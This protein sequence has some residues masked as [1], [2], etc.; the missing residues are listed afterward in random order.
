[1]AKNNWDPEELHRL[2][3]AMTIG[4]CIVDR[5]K[6]ERILFANRS[7]LELYDCA[8]MEE[9]LDLTGGKFSGMTM[10]EDLSL[11]SARG[12]RQDFFTLQVQYLTKTR[13]I[14]ELDCIVTPCRMYDTDVYLLQMTSSQMKLEEVTSDECTGFPGA[15]AF[16]QQ[17]LSAARERMNEGGFSRFC[18]VCF[19]IANFRGFNRENGMEEGNRC[20]A[21]TARVLREVFPEGLFGHTSADNFYAILP[22]ENLQEKIEEA[23][24]RVDQYMGGRSSSLKAGIVLFD[25]EVSPDVLRHAFD[26]ARIACNTVKNDAEHCCGVFRK[27]MQERIENR[28][29]ILD[30]FSEALQLGYLKVYY[31]PMVRALSGKVCGFE[32]LTRWED[33]VRG[34]I[35]PGI[36]VPILENAR[37][38]GRLDA[39]VIDRVAEFLHERQDAG[40][41]L[42]PVSVNFSRLD[43][44]LIHPLACLEDAVRTW[45]IP[46]EMIRAELTER[47]LEENQ[48]DMA[49]TLAQFHQA[50]YQLWLDDFGAEYSSLNALHRFDFDLIKLD[51]GFFRNFDEKSR[52]ILTSIVIM[53]KSLHIHTLAEGVETKEQLDF[54]RGIGCEIIQG[55][56]YGKPMPF[57]ELSEE[58]EKKGLLAETDAER[59]IYQAAGLVNLV[60]RT[61]QALLAC[62][63]ESARIITANPVF[64]QQ[65]ASTDT[66][67]PE[68]V[69]RYLEM[70]SFPLRFRLFGFLDKVF[71]GGTGVMGFS[72]HGQSFRLEGEKVAGTSAFWIA[73][74][75][76]FCIREETALRKEDQLQ[77]LAAQ[78]IAPLYDGI[79][80]INLPKDMITVLVSDR[81][82]TAPGLKRQGIRAAL[83]AFGTDLVYL[84]DRERFFAFLDPSG[85]FQ[86]ASAS[87]RGL[88][89]GLFRIRQKDGRYRWED[90]IAVPVFRDGEKSLLLY[91]RRSSWEE[92]P[93]KEREML[94]PVF[95]SS[96]GG[97][98]AGAVPKKQL[99]YPAKDL[100]RAACRFSGLAFYWLDQDLRVVGA[101]D[102]MLSLLGGRTISEIQ[103]RSFSELGWCLAPEECENV[104]KSILQ[105]GRPRTTRERLVLLHGVPKNLCVSEFPY[106][107][108]N[109]VA[110]IA[111]YIRLSIK[112]SDESR[113]DLD[114][115]TGFLNTYGILC[116]GASY[117]DAWRRG[118]SGYLGVCLTLTDYERLC[119]TL[120]KN[121]VDDA[122]RAIADAIRTEPLPQDAA[123]ARV[124]GCTFLILARQEN[125]ELAERIASSVQKSLHELREIGG[126]P[127]RLELA[128]S[129]AGA[130]EASDFLDLVSLL[131]RRCAKDPQQGDVSYARSL[132]RIGCEPE[133]FED[134]PERIV[135]LD[136]ETYEILYLNHAARKD[137]RL[138]DDFDYRG[139][140]C[141]EILENRSGICEKCVMPTFSGLPYLV[142]S[143]TWD[144]AS[145]QR[146]T[147][148]DMLVFWHG[149]RARLYISTPERVQ[150]E[151]V[152]A[153]ETW[154][155]E[156]IT[157]GLEDRDPSSGIGRSIACIGKNLQA[158]RLL[159][160]EKREGGTVQ[161]TYEWDRKGVLP[162]KPDLQSILM[163]RLA[164]L[165]R[166]FAARKVV[167]VEDYDA[168]LK[169]HPDFSLPIPQVRSFIAGHLFISGESLGF[170]LVLNAPRESF[171]PGG[172]MLSTLVDF[173]AVMLRTRNN[174]QK[175]T[176]QSLRD[177]MTG[178]LNRRGLARYL[179]KRTTTGTCTLL[180]GDINGLKR[181]NDTRG[182]EAGD[183]LIC[184]IADILL[185]FSDKEHVFRM[186]GDEFL[187]IQEG[188]DEAGARDLVKEIQSV[189]TARGCSIALGYA[190]HTGPLDDID[191]VLRRADQAMY[192]DKAKSLH[193]RSTDSQK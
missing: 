135:I 125:A 128:R 167:S 113:L 158:E 98:L 47:V 2:Y 58:L 5:T 33:P 106:Y 17:A 134:I 182:H 160:L 43:F 137:V 166:L 119:R 111:G 104:Q 59:A 109:E 108:G 65:L 95:T 150:S 115:L 54:L 49:R 55:Y 154:A 127:C 82:G 18:P 44:D 169:N 32:A 94:L 73:R 192:E 71:H 124:R 138:S 83:S 4:V 117:D 79:Y 74:V 90:W 162:L 114:T 180:S 178:T 107:R 34:M 8:G 84:D 20:L 155:N 86:Q 159:I 92:I 96:L 60:S 151:Q 26:M 93:E 156:A 172:F 28:Q 171:R 174:L 50:G 64:L 121:F 141:Y 61:P 48:G 132:N 126:M 157:L 177:P 168:F 139:K 36:Y 193:R 10:E 46:R 173:T 165:Q 39:Y 183:A 77:A 116:V 110:G 37:L 146:Y 181:M 15:R 145:S 63:K 144:A 53:A 16:F 140:K 120:G 57:S 190:V 3:D 191:A 35:S 7:A 103:G 185:R 112:E 14:R 6:K 105:T 100:F 148:R 123:V 88:A 66:K 189:C 56:Y 97:S 161:C 67:T 38:I 13:H 70:K 29:Y 87:G 176:L 136:P 51:M 11:A 12:S 143:T 62:E 101:S 75:S 102:A 118:G 187:L 85:L 68:E 30:H 184:T 21:F 147:T 80:D 76:L 170:S 129:M 188:M 89:V 22:R 41:R 40:M 153:D 78:N 133:T 122:A 149:R 163:T 1:M 142:R 23:C 19:N 52:A 81:Q 99:Q 164:P 186:G 175:A 152:L 42:L 31:Q 130:E 72:D 9:F 69:N 27:E 179:E 91:E 131:F 25:H 24:A 45:H